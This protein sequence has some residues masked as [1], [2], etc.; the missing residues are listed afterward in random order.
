MRT[1][2]LLL[3]LIQQSSAQALPRKCLPILEGDFAEFYEIHGKTTDLLPYRANI[4]KSIE[5]TFT[6]NHFLG[7]KF[8]LIVSD[9]RPEN[10]ALLV[11]YPKKWRFYSLDKEEYFTRE[12][13]QVD[14]ERLFVFKSFVFYGHSGFFVLN[15]TRVD[16]DQTEQSVSISGITTDELWNINTRCWRNDTHCFVEEGK[17]EETPLDPHYIVHA[18]QKLRVMAI[19]NSNELYLHDMISGFDFCFPET[20][21]THR[22]CENADKFS[23][24]QTRFP[25]VRQNSP[26]LTRRLDLIGKSFAE[27]MRLS[28][29]KESNGCDLRV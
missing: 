5:E 22:D 25:I 27:A 15:S 17:I 19:R 16:E 6:D 1:V 10:V 23:R 13:D 26:F 12:F 8:R 24:V 7:E 9:E 20:L 29:K 2:G 3:L 11:K 18:V 28:T 14:Y 4:N 21:K